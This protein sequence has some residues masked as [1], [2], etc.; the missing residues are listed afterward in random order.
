MARRA[1]VRQHKNP[2]SFREEIAVPA[3]AELLKSP[4]LPWEVDVGTAH[5]DFL[6][7]RAAQCPT[8]NVIG[9]E[10][11]E[12]MVERVLRKLE[13]S[14][15][16]N[17]SVIYCNANQSFSEFFPPGRLS[18]VYVYFPDPWFKKKH[19]KRRVL[20]PGFVDELA[21]TLR[22]GGELHF[23]SDHEGYAL[24]T[25]ELL[26]AHP[27]FENPHGAHARAPRDPDLP[28]S[29]REAWHETKGDPIYRH[30]WR[31]LEGSA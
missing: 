4:E 20:N 3:W 6:L 10:I 24:D 15:L 1:R 7:A 22:A 17:A 21:R 23:M 27:A 31:R 16:K 29:H 25:C 18:R 26:E 12:L 30:V 5:G 11:R 9:L 13:R 14:G 19:H 8:V 28:A 2:F